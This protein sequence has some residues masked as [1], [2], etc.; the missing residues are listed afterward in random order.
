MFIYLLSSFPFLLNY[1]KTVILIYYY[2]Y[3]SDQLSSSILLISDFILT[4]FFFLNEDLILSCI[5][6]WISVI[7][8]SNNYLILI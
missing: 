2:Y 8:I 6:V 3:N 5:V 4:A 7:N 1:N